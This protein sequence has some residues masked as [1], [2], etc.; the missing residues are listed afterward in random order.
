MKIVLFFTLNFL[1]IT[2][3]KPITIHLEKL[4]IKNSPSLR[5]LNSISSVYGNTHNLNYYYGYLYIGKEGKKQSY[6]LDT[7]SSITT[8][9]CNLC[10]DC[11]KHQ[12]G[13]YEINENNIIKCNDNKCSLVSNSCSIGG[14]CS[15]SISYTEGSSIYGKFINELIRFGDDY[16]NDIPFEFPIGC[17]NKETHLFRTQLADGIMGLQNSEKSFPSIL[18]NLKQIK[19]N[20]FTLCLGYEGGLFSIGEILND[21]HL[22]N[23]ISY[24]S[25][26]NNRFYVI[27]FLSINIENFN[28]KVNDENNINYYSIVDSGTTISYFPSK[29]ANELFHIVKTIC[30]RNENNGKCGEN[31]YDK[32]LGQ[33]FRFNNENDMN[34]ALDN[35]FPN[36]TFNF[37]DNVT[38]VWEPRNYY[39]HNS[40]SS[41]CLGFIGEST[42][43]FTLGTTF[44][45]GYDFIFDT[46]NSKIGFVKADCNYVFD[47]KITNQKND[48]NNDNKDN[49]DNNKDNNDNNRDNNDNKDNNG[50]INGEIQENPNEKNENNNVLNRNNNSKF[51]FIDFFILF[52]QITLI[53]TIISLIIYGLFLLGKNFKNKNN[54]Y[55]RGQI[56]LNKENNHDTLE[57][58]PNTEP[59]LQKVEVPVEEI[60]IDIDEH[61]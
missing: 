7:G 38:F 2:K 43:R 44:M 46:Q 34:Y 19:R 21:I 56:E 12:N 18:F 23:N 33:C 26:P 58:M 37:G 6:I 55:S 16:E 41:F 4:P 48:N 32:N 22:N 59:P 60:K 54:Y 57:I 50:N 42:S 35:I 28:V 30:N 36:I 27:N 29:F 39:F 13:L 31:F 52:G 51:Y 40:K 45:R 11:G 61:Q 49:N 5:N 47:K 9:P 1:L 15:F 20:L 3:I 8:S 53:I 10:K 24:L 25:I 14:D 17:T